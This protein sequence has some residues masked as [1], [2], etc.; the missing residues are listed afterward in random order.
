MTKIFSKSLEN[1]EVQFPTYSVFVGQKSILRHCYAQNFKDRIQIRV[2]K[3]KK[4]RVT[5]FC[6]FFSVE[7][8][9]I[10]RKFQAHSREKYR[11]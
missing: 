6:Q 11:A 3:I 2:F 7:V 10:L 8:K 1:H 9:K 5:S 4:D